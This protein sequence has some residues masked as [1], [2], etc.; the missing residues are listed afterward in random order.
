MLSTLSA[1]LARL[2]VP[3]GVTRA[4]TVRIVRAQVDE[5]WLNRCNLPGICDEKFVDRIIDRTALNVSRS[6]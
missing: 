1:V 2:C 3:Y 4:S 6:K 5:Q